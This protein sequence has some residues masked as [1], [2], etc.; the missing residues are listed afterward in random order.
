VQQKFEDEEEDE[1]EEKVAS[2]FNRPFPSNAYRN[3]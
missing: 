2:L 3:K 1:H